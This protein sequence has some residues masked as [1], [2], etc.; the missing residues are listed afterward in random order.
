MKEISLTQGKVALVDDEDFDRLNKFKWF[1]HKRH[2]I[3]YAGRQVTVVYIPETKYCKQKIVH[4][5][6]LI[7]EVPSDKM[8]DH[9]D[10]EGLN[11][12][13]SNLRA[14][15]NR[16]NLQNLHRRKKTSRFP[17]VSWQINDK[18]WQS[19]ICINRIHH[20]LGEFSS[21]EEAFAMYQATCAGIGDV[22]I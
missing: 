16:Q 4:M 21:E 22:V 1:A 2:G 19:G 5:H 3:F 13:K 15:T 12:Q 11:N 9:I 10:G 6:R 20:Y 17:G 8:I 7:M 18:K 14:V